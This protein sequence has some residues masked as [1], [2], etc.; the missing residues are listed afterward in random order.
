MFRNFNKLIPEMVK[1]SELRQIIK[2]KN[3]PIHERWECRD[4]K[5]KEKKFETYEEFLEKIMKKSNTK[6]LT[7]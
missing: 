2:Q 5:I 3:I 6:L 4:F 7:K 1:Y